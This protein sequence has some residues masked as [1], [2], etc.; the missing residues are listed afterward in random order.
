MLVNITEYFIESG[1]E[2]RIGE[3][4]DVPSEVAARWIADG[5]ATADT[6]GARDSQSLWSGGDVVHVMCN[7]F[8]DGAMPAGWSAWGGIVGATAKPRIVGG[9]MTFAPVAAGAGY[10]HRQFD[11]TVRQLSAEFELGEST[12]TNGSVVLIAW[13]EDFETNYPIIPTSPCHFVIS[14]DRWTYGTVTG[15]VVTTMANGIFVPALEAGKKY[16]AA[17]TIDHE[18]SRAFVYLP[19]GVVAT[20]S[21]AAI[22]E[23][24]ARYAVFEMYRQA[25]TDSI[26]AFHSFSATDTVGVSAAL[27]E[28][29][30]TAQNTIGAMTWPLTTGTSDIAVPTAMTDVDAANARLTGVIVPASGKVLFQVTGYLQQTAAASV[31]WNLTDAAMGSLFNLRVSETVQTGAISIMFVKGSLTPGRT[32]DVYMRHMTT[33]AGSANLQLSSANGRVITI[34]ATPLAA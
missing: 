18:N 33:V 3:N 27:H 13:E 28:A 24:R 17:V 14:R 2:W 1:R 5:K 9:V 10:L 29:A 7:K 23:S 26:G 16:S 6:D 31:L 20:V 15:G 32:L 22:G 34:K 19:N 11:G 25:A 8:A 21:H 4:P 30:A 12:T